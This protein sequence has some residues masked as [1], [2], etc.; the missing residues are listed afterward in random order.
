MLN[1]IAYYANGATT[2]TGYTN[3][4]PHTIVSPVQLGSYSYSVPITG[5]S[6]AD[7]LLGA[8]ALLADIESD[9][10][11]NRASAIYGL[12]SALTLN[13]NLKVS[14]PSRENTESSI[15]ATGTEQYTVTVSVSYEVG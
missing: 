8:D 4:T 12:D 2:P 11:T 14:S 7:P 9:F 6:N 13:I 5:I 15:F 10:D 3:P 1:T